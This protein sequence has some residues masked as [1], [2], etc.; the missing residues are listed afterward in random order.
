MPFL[1]FT[2]GGTLGPVTP[3]LAARK[4]FL[5]KHPEWE[6]IWF[7]TP[8]GPERALLEAEGIVFFPVPITRV[9]RYISVQA[10]AELVTLPIR[11]LRAIHEV[12]KELAMY[13]PALVI[14]AGGYTAAPVARVARKMHIPCYTHQLDRLPGMTNRM[15][16]ELCAVRTTSFVYDHPVFG[17]QY[18]AQPIA[19]PT[20]FGLADLPGRA[21]ALSRLGLDPCKKTILVMGGGT[22]AQ[23]LNELA[24]AS[25]ARWLAHGWQ[26]LHLT[27]EG[28]ASGYEKTNGV[29]TKPLCLFPEIKTWFAAADVV[30]TRAG[31]GTLSELTACK[32]PMIIVPIAD[33]HQEQNAAV[34]EAQQAA[35]VLSQ[36]DPNLP[37]VVERALGK[38]LAD[39]RFAQSMTMR[40]SL[41][42]PTDRGQAMAAQWEGLLEGKI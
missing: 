16:A 9:P 3:L 17:K 2:G 24:A 37:H 28:K 20:R 21:Q 42:L 15:I 25:L 14:S 6:T 39:E 7:G 29:V 30:I 38:L 41:T 34:F 8:Q 33:S 4:Q 10:L 12:R 19:T 27:G 13:K 26:V 40:A 1:A 11:Y 36:Q 18:P 23:A 31:M 32:K 5:T 35:F 22:G